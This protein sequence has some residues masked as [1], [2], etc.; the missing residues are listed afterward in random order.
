MLSFSCVVQSGCTS[1][2]P[3]EHGAEIIHQQRH[4]Y[5]LGVERQYGCASVCASVHTRTN[6]DNTLQ[7]TRRKASLQKEMLSFTAVQTHMLHLPCVIFTFTLVSL[8]GGQS[9]RTCRGH[10]LTSAQIRPVIGI[11]ELDKAVHKLPFL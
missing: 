6:A 7:H 11:E 10:D 3:A 4:I 9:V 2:A 8:S 5:V 1:H